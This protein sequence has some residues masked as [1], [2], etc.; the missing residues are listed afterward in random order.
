MVKEAFTTGSQIAGT[1]IQKQILCPVNA[2]AMGG[3]ASLDQFDTVELTRSHPID[4]RPTLGDG[5]PV[6]DGKPDGWLI[7]GRNTVTAAVT[8]DLYVVCAVPVTV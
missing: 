1:P 5:T 4:V 7:Y 8:G 2:Y 6:P 3:G